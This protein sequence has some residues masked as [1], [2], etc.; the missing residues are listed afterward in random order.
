[1]TLDVEHGLEV[2]TFYLPPT[3]RWDDGTAVQEVSREQLRCVLT[4]VMRFWE[5]GADFVDR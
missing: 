3:L 4:D 2:V 1:V 5:T